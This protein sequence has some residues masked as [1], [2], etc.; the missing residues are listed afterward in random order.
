VRVELD[1]DRVYV[2]SGVTPR[3]TEFGVIPRPARAG[4]GHPR[5]M[6]PTSS[7]IGHSMCCDG[8]QRSNRVPLRGLAARVV[9][10]EQTPWEVAAQLD[11][12]A[13]PPRLARN[14]GSR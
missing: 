8:A 7:P 14:A 1:A 6:I 3:R 12:A 2:L 4:E 10:S 13:V 5:G 11:G 9:V